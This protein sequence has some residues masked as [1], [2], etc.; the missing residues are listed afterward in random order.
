[1]GTISLVIGIIG[2][3]VPLLPT[4]VFLLIAAACYARASTRLYT[5]LVSHR[6][7]G[8]IILEWRRSRSFPAGVKPR[9]LALVVAAFALSIIVV[10]SLP[11][12]VVLL[13]TGI[14]LLVFLSRIPSAPD[15]RS[16]GTMGEPP[17]H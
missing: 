6:T 13:I 3:F 11:I 7:F 10:D 5:W 14:V 17:P 16:S 4:T 15:G 1:V 2:I 9:V 8:P 12:R